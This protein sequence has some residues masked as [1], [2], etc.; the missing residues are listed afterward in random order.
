MAVQSPEPVGSP[1]NKALIPL[2]DGVLLEDDHQWAAGSKTIE[3]RT[4]ELLEDGYALTK[5]RVDGTRL[6]VRRTP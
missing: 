4:L 2:P 3:Q 1:I 6:F 5:T